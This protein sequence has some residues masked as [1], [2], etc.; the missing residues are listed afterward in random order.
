MGASTT[1][2]SLFSSFAG[3]TTSIS[4]ALTSAGGC[5]SCRALHGE[6]A[7]GGGTQLSKRAGS[8]EGLVCPLWMH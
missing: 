4:T 8:K 3:A 1:S 7:H 2:K 6:H 5:S